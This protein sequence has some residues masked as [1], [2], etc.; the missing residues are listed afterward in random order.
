MR[1]RCRSGALGELVSAR[2]FP[3]N[4]TFRNREISLR[5]APRSNGRFRF[6]HDRVSGWR[7]LLRRAPAG[8][9][10]Q[11]RETG[12]YI[13]LVPTDLAR[14]PRVSDVDRG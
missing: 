3:L 13:N 7:H 1:L 9:D 12:D 10:A 5:E 11:N 14:T 4:Q 6:H 8:L 2:P